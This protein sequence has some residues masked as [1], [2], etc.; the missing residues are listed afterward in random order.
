MFSPNAG[1][2]QAI[3]YTG[4]EAVTL[5][6]L[7]QLIAGCSPP[8]PH[9]PLRASTPLQPDPIT[10]TTSWVGSVNSDVHDG[11]AANAEAVD[12]ATTS[13]RDL[14]KAFD[15]FASQSNLSLLDHVAGNKVRTMCTYANCAQSYF[16]GFLKCFLILI[17]NMKSKLYF[18]SKIGRLL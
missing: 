15:T 8:A 14:K 18:F 3:Y 10:L 1:R 13:V 16:G 6:G 2:R 7:E 12:I 17:T 11:G 4:E 5:E 9:Q